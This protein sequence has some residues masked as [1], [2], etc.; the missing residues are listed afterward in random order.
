MKKQ[1]SM[2]STADETDKG[3]CRDPADDISAA[4]TIAGEVH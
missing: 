2:Q 4:R 1:E 3:D